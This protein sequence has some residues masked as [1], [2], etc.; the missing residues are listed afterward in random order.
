MKNIRAGIVSAIVLTVLCGV[1][2]PLALTAVSQIAFNKQANGSLIVVDGEVVGSELIGQ[3]FDD[4]R[5]FSSRPSAI[6]YTMDGRNVPSGS[7]NM[8]ASDP[9]LKDR[10]AQEIIELQDNNP[11]LRVDEIP[12]DMVTESASGLDPHISKE[13][14]MIQVKRVSLENGLSENVVVDL[15]I[16]HVDSSGHVNVVLLNLALTTLVAT[17]P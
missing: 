15:I 4:P 1:I 14:A 6:N 7:S 11:G 16:N 13:G 2:Y 12:L 5:F 9:L 8:A 3:S 17:Q 10:I